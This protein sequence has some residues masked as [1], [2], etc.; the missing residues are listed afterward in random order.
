MAE[1]RETK[2][3][4]TF[5]TEVSNYIARAT[6]VIRTASHDRFHWARLDSTI[7]PAEP[8]AVAMTAA[9]WI[10][11]RSTLRDWLG[12]RTDLDEHG[13]MLFQIGEGLAEIGRRNER[14]RG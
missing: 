8:E 9:M 10:S 6:E 11:S 14:N 7:L 5:V 1:A 12:S 2:S 4:V 13:R 3:I